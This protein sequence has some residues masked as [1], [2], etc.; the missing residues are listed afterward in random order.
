[1]ADLFGADRLMTSARELTKLH[2]T[3]W[4]G[5]LTEAIAFF[6]EHEPK[7]EFTLVVAGQAPQAQ[8]MLSDDELKQ[9]LAALIDQGMTRSQASRHLAQVTPLPRRHLY[10]LALELVVDEVDDEMANGKPG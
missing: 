6:A 10:Q 8:R 4:R 7:G 3:F 9:E 5:T 1:M 2:E